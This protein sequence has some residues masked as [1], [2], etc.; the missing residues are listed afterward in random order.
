MSRSCLSAACCASPTDEKVTNPK[1]LITTVCTAHR[2]WKTAASE[3]GLVAGPRPPTYTVQVAMGQPRGGSTRNAL[4][5]RNAPWWR[6]R[7]IFIR[8]L[9]G[10]FMALSCATTFV[11]SH[12]AFAWRLA[13]MEAY[14]VSLS[15][16]PRP[17]LH[18]VTATR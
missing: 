11:G 4:G 3:S 13:L 16:R 2:G 8:V 12:Y 6:K 15:H 5:W 17:P 10:G 9:G 1:D 14:V 7:A 18:V